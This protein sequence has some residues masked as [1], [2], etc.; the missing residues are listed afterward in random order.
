MA[1][2]LPESDEF[3]DLGTPYR[4]SVD[5]GPSHNAASDIEPDGHSNGWILGEDTDGETYSMSRNCMDWRRKVR[6]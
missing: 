6:T 2:G 5:H 4:V 1:L 3:H